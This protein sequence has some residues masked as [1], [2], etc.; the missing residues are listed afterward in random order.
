MTEIAEPKSHESELS[1]PYWEA[2]R[3]GVF[4]IQKCGSCGKLRH[5]PQLVCDACHS[6]DYAWVEVSGRGKVHSWTVARHAFHPA[7]AGELPYALVTVE[8]DEGPR[9]LGRV[10][11]LRLDELKIGLEVS[12]R[13]VI[14][15]NGVPKLTFSPVG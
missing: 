14:A 7:F 1:A 12:A 9:A 5:Y 10:E 2:A 6:L 8:L 4:R 11:G 3:Q 15:E 13:F